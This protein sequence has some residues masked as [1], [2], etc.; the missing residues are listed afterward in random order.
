VQ[1]PGRE[2]AGEIPVALDNPRFLNAFQG[3]VTNYGQPSY[4]ELDPTPIIA[5]TFPLVFG[6]M[7]GDVGQGL[8]VA[9][10]GLLL[11]S[12]RL[13]AL[14][15]LAGL[16]PIMIA[17]GL[18]ATVFGALYGSIFGFEGVF[19]PLWIRPVESVTDI[20]LATVGVGIAILC[21]G[22]VSHIVNSAFARRW[23]SMIFSSN[24]ITGLIFYLA[25][26]GIVATTMTGFLPIGSGV[27]I[28]LALVS[29][30]AVTLS[31]LLARWVDGKHPLVEGGIG[32]YIV[33]AAFELFETLL[34]MLSNTLSYVR[35]G[36]FA[37]AHG[38][39]SMVVFILADMVGSIR[40]PGYWLVVI[41]GNLFVI[42]FEGMIVSIQTL[43]LEYYE[44]FSKFFSGSGLQ[45][46][47]FTL[48][49]R[50]ED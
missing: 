3:L 21:L 47:P 23:G 6:I 25:M 40:S 43:R 46:H 37:V 41:I 28:L 29:G 10:V 2:Q 18:A 48:I 7:F 11:T 44:F 5:L 39:L 26:L 24:G 9:L 32:T 50:G 19:A 31:E 34:S 22:M 17:C 33:Q 38:A 35:M 49:T 16:G 45:H 30:I 20:L 12:K 4:D 14:K 13:P 1:L 15:S 27:F 8:L 42:G 36:A